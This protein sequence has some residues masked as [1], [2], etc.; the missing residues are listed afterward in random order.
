MQ[1]QLQN[2]VENKQEQLLV[3]LL[4]LMELL[5]SNTKIDLTVELPKIIRLL[6]LKFSPCFQLAL[7]TMLRKVLMDKLSDKL[8]E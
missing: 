3:G 5:F 8:V 6:C 2:F 4:Q 7:L 1:P